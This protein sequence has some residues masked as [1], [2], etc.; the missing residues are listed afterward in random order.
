MEDWIGAGAIISQLTG[1][2]SPEVSA[3]LAAFRN[4]QSQIEVV[5]RQ[6]SSGKELI[7]RGFEADLSLATALNASQ[8]VPSLV[9][10]AYRPTAM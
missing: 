8:C 9:N 1:Q 2:L 5:V 4:T 7:E 6:S 10:G 3:A